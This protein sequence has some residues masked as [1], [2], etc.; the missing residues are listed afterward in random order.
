VEFWI[1][2]SI[3]VTGHAASAGLD[4]VDQIL[5]HGFEQLGDDRAP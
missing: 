1:G 2:D 4:A 3:V 5:L